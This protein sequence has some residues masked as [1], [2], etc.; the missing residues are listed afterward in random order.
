MSTPMKTSAR[1]VEDM[2]KSGDVTIIQRITRIQALQIVL[3]LLVIVIL[4]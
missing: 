4:V 3:V 2:V 1:D